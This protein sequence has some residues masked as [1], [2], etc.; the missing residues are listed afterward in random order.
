M[1]STT[2]KTQQPMKP[3]HIEEDFGEA[4]VLVFVVL[5]NQSS[6]LGMQEI[7]IVPFNSRGERGMTL[8]ILEYVAVC[9]SL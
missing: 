5:T 9:V 8:K 6:K 4:F 3:L 2:L 7:K 1:L